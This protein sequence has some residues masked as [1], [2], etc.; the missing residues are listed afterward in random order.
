MAKSILIVDDNVPILM[1]L[2]TILEMKEKYDC[3]ITNHSEKAAEI[4]LNVKF[5]CIITDVVFYD[6][7]HCISGLD[8]TKKLKD[9]GYAGK[10]VLM[11]GYKV[12]EDINLVSNL[13]DKLFVKPV[14]IKEIET[15]LDENI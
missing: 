1:Q 5:D 11:T 9:M 10:I 13:F 2:K 8:L 14:T 6:C 3:V 7:E 15:W 4:A 12:Q